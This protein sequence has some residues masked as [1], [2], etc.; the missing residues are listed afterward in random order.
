MRRLTVFLAGVLALLVW[1]GCEQP[2]GTLPGEPERAA[3]PLASPRAGMV[4]AGAR[5][6]LFTATEGAEV[7]YTT[8]GSAPNAT[9]TRYQNPIVIDAAL[10]IK[11]VAVKAG[12]EDSAVLEAAYELDPNIVVPPTAVPP[13][14]EVAFE[15]EVT[16]STATEGAEIYYTIDGS[17]PDTTKTRYAGAILIDMPLTIKAIAAKEGMQTSYALEAVYTIAEPLEKAT[18][19]AAKP[20]A[21]TVAAGTSVAL[22]T[23]TEGAEIYYTLDGTAP[24]A[25]KTKYTVPITISASLTI[26]AI[27]LQEGLDPSET[28]EAVYIVKAETPAA[29]PAGGIVDS[30]AGVTLSTA[31]EGAAIY[32]TL[33]GSAPDGTKTKYTDPITIGASLTIRAIAVQEGMEPSE[34]LEAV[35]IV[36]AETPVASPGAGEVDS[37]AAVALST[38]TEGAEIYYTLDGTAPDRTK[39]KYTSPISITA[40]VVIRAIAVKEGLA[41]SGVLAAAYTVAA[42]GTTARPSANPAAGEVLAGTAVT[43]STTTAD[44][45]IYYTIDGSAPD[46][47]KTKYTAPISI[48]AAVTIRAIAV[49]AGR[50]DSALLEAAYTIAM[51]AKPT[52][53][54]AAGELNSGATVRLATTT[55]GADIYYTLDGSAADRTKTKYTGPISIGGAVTIRAIA[56]KEGMTDSAALEA[57]Y[58]VKAAMPSASPGAGVVL[59]GTAVTLSTATAGADIYYTLDGSA[60]D[61]TK[62]W[63]SGPISITAAV[64]IRAIAVKNGMTDSAVLEAAYSLAVAARPAASPGAGEVLDGT[65]VTLSTATAGAEIYYTTDGSV[66]NRNKT[67]YTAP[68]DIHAVQTV[69][70]IAVKEGMTDSAIL[71]AV[72]TVRAAMPAASPEPGEVFTGMG[73]ALTTDTVGAEIYYTLDGS[74]PSRTKTRYT[75]QISVTAALTIRAITV[76]P[77]MTDSDIL[78]AAYTIAAT[79]T[80]EPEDPE[81]PV[82]TR[83]EVLSPPDVT[84][85]ARGQPY[86]GTGGL[87]VNEFYSDGSVKELYSYTVSPATVDTTKPGQKIIYVRSGT[88]SA[89]YTVVVDQSDSILM[90]MTLKQGPSKTAYEFGQN[91]SKTGIA[92]TGFYSDGSEKEFDGGAC[93]FVGYDR[94]KRGKQSITLKINQFSFTVD[95]TVRVP[96]SATVKVNRGHGVD[97]YQSDYRRVFF[98]GIPFDVDKWNLA[99]TVTANGVSGILKSGEDFTLG[100][101]NLTGFNPNQ[102][103][104]QDI[105]FDLDDKKGISP[106]WVFVV[107]AEPAVWFDYGYQR[108]ASDP[109]GVGPGQGKYYAR[110]GETLVLAPVR[111]LIGWNDDYSPGYVSYS[112]SVSGGSYTGV[113]SV[114]GETYG[115]T[116]A[117]EGSYTITVYVTGR[118]VVTGG[119]ITK[120]AVTEVVCYTGTV[121]PGKTFVPPLKD[122]GCGQFAGGGTGNGWSLGTWG[123]YEVWRVESQDSYLIQ[124]NPFA[125]WCEPGVVWLQ[126]DRNNNGIPD[127]MWYELVGDLENQRIT[128]RYAVTYTWLG[129]A[130]ADIVEYGTLN[131][132]PFAAWVDSKGRVGAVHGGFPSGVGSWVTFTGTILADTGDIAVGGKGTIDGWGYV[133]SFGPGAPVHHPELEW[134]RFHV[135][136]AIKADGSAADL[137]AVRFIKVHTGVFQYGGAYGDISTEIKLADGLEDQSGGFPDPE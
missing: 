12:L 23:V 84:F 31:T 62:T 122:F 128:R 47:T 126:E 119:S 4:G 14:G 110:P 22:S 10:T 53:S 18:R 52:A 34:I 88:F 98:K 99:A 95:V 11:A 16:L 35:Y 54:P 72:Y 43:L 13:A 57:A 6:A 96:A 123:G 79:E 131:T 132:H 71:E 136:N 81:T 29:S 105:T 37:G 135:V 86:A 118:N 108:T 42:P 78:T 93:S 116:P 106:L 91:F 30:G 24:D 89:Y 27:A 112:W 38:A 124:G 5:V 63:Y 26:R 85:Y 61:R 25:T 114:S 17:E 59:T 127:E 76:K 15:T 134:G 70:A 129:Y 65:G 121:S 20:P 36:K 104:K 19:P 8:D 115:F 137:S 48:G 100:E 125:G 117:A 68:I 28:L 2:A 7:Y 102:T 55:V 103:G 50:A 130:T 41:D 75:G 80:P 69:R 133:D 74:A 82:V 39:T 1:T 46:R 94:I 40:A 44:A 120:S 107:E 113:P 33:D 111:Y 58:T 32:Y 64:T 66:P 49:K 73:I 97:L 45:E 109:N 56:A 87:R 92:F 77:G 9:K 67:K 90:N 83:I 21:G 101:I 3:M 60:P 51:A